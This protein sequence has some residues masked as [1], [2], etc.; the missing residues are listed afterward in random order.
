M[1]NNS[2]YFC[3]FHTISVSVI[4]PEITWFFNYT[5]LI[6]NSNISHPCQKYLDLMISGIFNPSELSKCP[7]TDIRTTKSNKKKQ[8]KKQQKDKKDK[9]T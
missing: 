9:K 7:K 1:F 3:K 4:K 8:K 5:F 2:Y 6:S